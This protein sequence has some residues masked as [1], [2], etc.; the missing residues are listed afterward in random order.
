VDGVHA[1]GAT[2]DRAGFDADLWPLPTDPADDR[3][4][5]DGLPAALAR[6]L[7]QA[8]PPLDG[9]AGLRAATPDRLPL[10]G[11]VPDIGGY[12]EVFGFLRTEGTRQ[13][14]PS[15]PLLGGQMVLGGLA[16]RGLMTAPLLAEAVVSALF[17]EPLPIP[18]D[19]AEALHPA[20]FVIRHLRRG[21]A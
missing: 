12:L 16:S 13:D 14:G 21:R 1:L 2:Y 20:R 8:G 3:R 11:P 18:R 15:A 6:L 19:L 10:A 17:G 4:N 9:R 5:L 7:E